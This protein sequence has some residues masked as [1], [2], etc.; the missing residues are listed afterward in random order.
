MLVPGFRETYQF[1][2]A[3]TMLEFGHPQLV[4]INRLVKLSR[5]NES[6]QNFA[7]LCAAISQLP[8]KIVEDTEKVLIQIHRGEFV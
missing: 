8:G 4:I 3:A 1:T 2:L 5:G 6:D 7:A